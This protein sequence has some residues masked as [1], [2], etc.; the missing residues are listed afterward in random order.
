VLI[1]RLVADSLAAAAGKD[2]FGE[3]VAVA[4]EADLEDSFSSVSRSSQAVSGSGHAFLRNFLRKKSSQ[5]NDGV[6]DP[7]WISNNN[8]VLLQFL[9]AT[10]TTFNSVPVPFPPPADFYGPAYV[11]AAADA[12][13]Q[14]SP[15]STI[16]D[17]LDETFETDSELVNVEWSCCLCC[18]VH[19]EADS[20][21]KAAA[22]RKSTNTEAGRNSSRPL[23]E[24]SDNDTRASSGLEGGVTP[25]TPIVRART[26]EDAGSLMS[27][28]S[29]AVTTVTL[30]SW[31]QPQ[32]LLPSTE[33]PPL[34]LRQHQNPGLR[35]L[36]KDRSRSL[37]E[38]GEKRRPSLP[39]RASI[40]GDSE[41][42]SDTE[43]RLGFPISIFDGRNYLSGAVEQPSD[44]RR[45]SE[46]GRLSS[47]RRSFPHLLDLDKCEKGRDE[48]ETKRS[49]PRQP[50]QRNAERQQR[51]YVRSVSDGAAAAFRP[52]VPNHYD[53]EERSLA[54]ARIQEFLAV[55]RKAAADAAK[56]AVANCRKM[57][58]DKVEE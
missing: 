30:L 26:D 54:S 27:T 58:G 51:S 35:H 20:C 25:A 14:P 49:P 42:L 11:D 48:A 29:S 39:R 22:T 4:S 34:R 33:P 6:G 21:R 56:A 3:G 50:P 18:D 52:A 38:F 31:A 43:E 36:R 53:L 15:G 7:S 5:A 8:L 55:T 28:P 37:F 32:H 44:R 19:S 24:C 17:L 23:G 41:S 45:T 12:A 46:V 40:D 47:V 2:C 13:K 9:R 57:N 16:A 10:T 1:D